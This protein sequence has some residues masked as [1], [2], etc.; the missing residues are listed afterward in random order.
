M[1]SKG[2]YII[3]LTGNIATGKSVVAAML[4]ELGALVID[5]DALAHEVMKAGTPTW[6]R[7]VDEF[8][9]DILQPDGEINRARLGARVFADPEA[10]K[11]LETI[12]HPAVIAESERL[13]LQWQ[14]EPGVSATGCTGRKVA[15][16]EAIKLI[17]SGM[18][19]QCDE[20]WVVTCPY[21]QQ[22]Q[23]LME[24]RGLGRAEAELRI[25]AQPPQEEKI[26]IAD[27][28]IDNSGDLERTRAQVLREWQRICRNSVESDLSAPRVLPTSHSSRD[29]HHFSLDTHHSSGGNMSSWRKF[30]DEHPFLTMWAILAVGMVVIFLV[31][32]RDVELLP[33]QRLFMAVACVLLA[34][35]CAWIV[36]WE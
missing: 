18:H 3:G 33:S 24:N 13:L 32:S 8:G 29:T 5:A 34:G 19:R 21:E 36:S 20:L 17:E 35:L 1:K 2:L 28:V 25:H 4:A 12:V 30:M 26:A 14:N 16:L 6:Q 22:V 31:T 15:V 9:P 7:V 10:L 23:R 27:V 11:R